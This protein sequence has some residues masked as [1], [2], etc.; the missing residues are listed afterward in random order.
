MVGERL[1]NFFK[2][3]L[4]NVISYRWSDLW[5]NE[6]LATYFSYLA[7]EASDVKNVGFKTYTY[8][9][10]TAKLNL[11]FFLLKV[12]TDF[13]IDHLF[14]LNEMQTM[15][16]SD[17]LETSHSIN[18]AVTQTNEIVWKFDQVSYRKGACIVRMFAEVLG[19]DI[20]KLGMNKY[21]QKL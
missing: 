12:K 10:I 21:L 13:K 14:I 16:Y 1:H 19:K 3:Y 9:T 5:L 7:L 4:F 6:G 11:S 17:A 15:M 18:L 8:C 2:C 20:F